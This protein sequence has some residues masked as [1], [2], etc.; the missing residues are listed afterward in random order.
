M[1]QQQAVAQQAAPGALLATRA[2]YLG[3]GV[4]GLRR[5]FVAK[6]PEIFTDVPG[7]LLTAFCLPLTVVAGLWG[8]CMAAHGCHCNN[9]NC[10]AQHSLHTEPSLGL[11]SPHSLSVPPW[12]QLP[13]GS[14]RGV[15]QPG[16][17]WG[18]H[19]AAVPAAA[20]VLVCVTSCC[21]PTIPGAAAAWVLLHP[22]SSA[23]QH[24]HGLDRSCASQI[25]GICT[26]ENL[27]YL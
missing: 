9:K 11:S 3:V 5:L 6:P 23:Q 12:L 15:C 2:Y 22:W 21:N 24:L 4:L 19:G 17:K 26:T 16:G 14:S 18:L 20:R 8:T 10:G 25:D 1:Q 7:Q 27:Y 13:A